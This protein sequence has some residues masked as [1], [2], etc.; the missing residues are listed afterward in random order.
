MDTSSLPPGQIFNLAVLLGSGAALFLVSFSNRLQRWWLPLPLLALGWGALVG[1]GLGW[2]NPSMIV[3]DDLLL[4]EGTRLVLAVALMAIALRLPHGFWRRQ[5]RFVAIVLG[6]GMPVMWLTASGVIALFTGYGAFTALLLGA[7]VTP[8]DPVVS[9][10]IVTGPTA[11]AHVPAWMRYGISAE[12]GS[13]D[14]LGMLFVLLPIFLLKHG[15]GAE[16]WQHWVLHGVLKEIALAIAVGG[17]CGW[18]A[19]RM[20]SVMK[21]MDEVRSTAFLAFTLVFPVVIL[22]LARLLHAD[23][24]LAAFIAG[25]IYSRGESGADEAEEE[26]TQEAVNKLMMVVFFAFVGIHLP[27]AEWGAELGAVGMIG[28]TAVLLLRRIVPIVLIHRFLRPGMTG[29][30]TGFL[31]WFAPVGAAAVYYVKLSEHELHRTD[32]WIP[33]SFVIAVSVVLHGFTATPATLRFGRARHSG[34]P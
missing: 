9:S 25:V 10:P 8:T 28:W 14:G 1:P 15:T 29:P 11:R 20:Y 4:R 26:E 3:H 18:F 31:A 33:V 22:T 17:A 6:I 2:L 23:G 27:V 13:N 21:R 5:G 32:L 19:D 7:I 24:I 34:S 16:G 12:S 30:E